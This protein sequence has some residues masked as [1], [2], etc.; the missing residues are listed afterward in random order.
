MAI[1]VSYGDTTDFNNF[2]YGEKH[3]GT[4]QFLENQI[5]NVSQYLTDAGKSFFS[6][7]RNLY[8]QFN[9]SEAMRLARAARQKISNLFQTDEIKPMWDIA[10]IQNAPPMM[11]RY[12][13]SEPT[14]RKLFMEQRIDGY[15]DSYIDMY[16]GTI[17]ETHYDYRRVMNGVVTIDKTGLEKTTFYLDELAEGDRELHLDEKVIILNTWEIVADLMKYGDRDPTSVFNNKL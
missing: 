6:N 11:Q 7:A 1:D 17:G 13:M 10:S 2:I 12:I 16:P 3:Q 14:T 9:S 8:N 4:L 5:N 15:S